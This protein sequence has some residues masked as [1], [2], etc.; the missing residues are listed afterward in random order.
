[1]TVRKMLLASLAAA[2]W[3]S[4]P[5]PGLAQDAPPE[6]AGESDPAS[7]PDDGSQDALLQTRAEQIVAVLKGD[8]PASD[9]FSAGFLGAV[10]PEQLTALAA[11][12]E[13]QFGTLAGVDSVTP[14][15]KGSA[16]VALRYER[17]IARGRMELA[18]DSGQLVNGLL[19]NDFET[20]DDSVAAVTSDIAALPGQVSVLYAPLDRWQEP[21]IA[22]EPDR[23]MAIGSAFKL[24][25][26]SDLAHA[27]AKGEIGWDQL[28]RLDRRSLPSGRMQ[29][30]PQ[31]TPVS[32][33][34]LAIMMISISD[35][36]AT[37]QLIAL[38][39]RDSL[40]GEVR[41]S[42]H[43]APDRMLPFLSTLELFAL[44]GDTER[45]GLYA[46]ASEEEQAQILATLDSETG[47]DARNIAPPTFAEPHAIDTLEW[48]ASAN[49]L[50][51]VLER[52]QQLDEPI[53]RDIL[54]VN[55]SLTA[56]MREKWAYVGFKG[57]SEPGV[58][59]LS[60][61]LQD[62][63]GAWFVLVLSWNDPD[64]PLDN[65][66]LELLAQRILGL[67]R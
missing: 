55:P 32:V 49:D 26:L 31:Q 52:I 38:L 58:L 29:D 34:T 43:S 66:R 3:A 17:A 25:V 60:W 6:T 2:L 1:M 21:I 4:A 28:V 16:I 51:G 44:K 13:D 63:S 33:A 50:R 61:L 5:V 14:T 15:G 37:D 24:Y 36:T 12:M 65:S 48:F 64:A 56:P 23:Q 41:A 7:L 19:F 10:S 11:Q 57:G 42:G 27:A 35:N 39:G 46:A 20:L 8:R 9:V 62:K 30:W 18:P 54:A 59:N 45:G 67:K 47:G 40:A 53:A 22:I